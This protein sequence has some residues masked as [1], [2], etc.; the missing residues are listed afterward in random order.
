MNI[1]K[2]TTQQCVISDLK[3]YQGQSI[4]GNDSDLIGNA[5]INLVLCCA[6]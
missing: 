1:D 2:A 6:I 3:T 5:W 4:I